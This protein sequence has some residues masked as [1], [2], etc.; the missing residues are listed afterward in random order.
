MLLSIG[1]QGCS[2]PEDRE[3]RI[4]VQEVQK[5]HN[6]RI[7]SLKKSDGWLSLT[8]LYWL[9]EGRNSFGGSEKNNIKFAGINLPPKM[10]EFLLK[11]S[12]IFIEVEPG[13]TITH[14]DQPILKMKLS[15]NGT[16]DPTILRY[17]SLLWYVIKRGD[18]YAIRLKDSQSESLKN[19]KGIETYPIQSKW[20]VTANFIPYETPGTIEV[21]NVLGTIIDSPSP[22]KLSFT[23]ENRNYTLDPIADPEDKRWFIIFGDETNGEETYGAGRYM[24]IDAPGVDGTTIIDFNKSYNPPCVFTP[25]AT[26]SLPPDQNFLEIR[27]TAG[28]KY[29]YGYEH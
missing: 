11:D 21:P 23:L 12:V 10:G 5:W 27:L 3:D 6:K 9:K 2:K 8:G 4:Y 20:R 26:C 16:G 25:Y 19:F 15:Y 24:Y 1:F 17:Q 22:G 14:D 13:I 29:Y 28:E 18:R 7:A